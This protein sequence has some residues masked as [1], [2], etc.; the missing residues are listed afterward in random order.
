MLKVQSTNDDAEAL[1]RDPPLQNSRHDIS[2]FGDQ[3]DP[4]GGGG[5]GSLDD[6]SRLVYYSVYLF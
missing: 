1:F 2:N 3:F 4:M 6:M 5:F